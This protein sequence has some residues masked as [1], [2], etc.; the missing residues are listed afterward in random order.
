MAKEKTKT[1]AIDESTHHAIHMMAVEKKLSIKDYLK[2]LVERE[3]VSERMNTNY[4][5]EPE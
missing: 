5:Q 2:K 4:K 3:K 1:I